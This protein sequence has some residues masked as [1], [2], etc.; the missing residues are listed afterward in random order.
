MVMQKR[1]A[2]LPFLMK[3]V[4]MNKT[5]QMIDEAESFLQELDP[6]RRHEYINGTVSNTSLF[7]LC[8]EHSNK[9]NN[10]AFFKM[11]IKNGLVPPSA[12]TSAGAGA[13]PNVDHMKY[14][15]EACISDTSTIE[16]LVKGDKCFDLISYFCSNLNTNPDMDNIDHLIDILTLN[17]KYIAT[18]TCA[19]KYTPLMIALSTCKP[20]KF[21][22]SL[23]RYR[24]DINLQD[25]K[26]KTALHC[27]IKSSYDVSIVEKL[28][29]MGACTDIV[30]HKNM[31]MLEFAIKHGVTIECMRALISGM[32][33]THSEFTKGK[34]IISCITKWGLSNEKIL[35]LFIDN[36]INLHGQGEN[37]NNIAHYAASICTSPQIL[38]E[39]IIAYKIY[40]N[41]PNSLLQCPLVIAIHRSATPLV[42]IMLEHGASVNASYYYHTDN[43]LDCA[44][45]SKDFDIVQLLLK[46]GAVGSNSSL[47]NLF[48][49]CSS[50][51]IICALVRNRN[52]YGSD[53]TY[54]S[55]TSIIDAIANKLDNSVIVTLLK[56]GA[57]IN[58][59]KCLDLA[60]EAGIIDLLLDPATVLNID[61][62]REP[63]INWA[64]RYH[65]GIATKI[66]TK[67]A[68]LNI[69]YSTC[70]SPIKLA[71][72][73]KVSFDLLTLCIDNYLYIDRHDVLLFAINHGC[74]ISIIGYL[75]RAGAQLNNT[76]KHRST[77]FYAL[78]KGYA[79]ELIIDDITGA[80]LVPNC[81]NLLAVAL[82][83]R[84]D[85][86]I[87]D[88]LL[89]LYDINC[90]YN[91]NSILLIALQCRADISIIY[92]LLERGADIY[93]KN[94]KN[95]SNIFTH[96]IEYDE[97]RRDALIRLIFGGN[98]V[99]TKNA[100]TIKN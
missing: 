6:V 32:H 55:N 75:I 29:S 12:S 38:K 18:Q 84:L 44:I 81:S 79:I 52:D 71:I 15:F 93:A 30:A 77:A 22:E 19:R 62:D 67:D 5:T 27:A 72:E 96:I 73:T 74:D 21:I 58:I 34:P 54:L 82:E 64:L 46:H 26:H 80:N 17:G 43:P 23:L 86:N 36:D 16:L 83:Q 2:E 100:R 31:N 87:V 10:E 56:Y 1:S 41:Q 28:I 98:R 88:A 51:D 94:T 25:F 53:H 59:V 40:I 33:A 69:K 95:K 78:I 90:R 61:T 3:M 39:I 14:F 65:P 20:I 85:I 48:K 68:A 50:E 4:K 57:I 91:N 92:L 42:E 37:G 7:S 89:N 24:Q 70:E 60:L 97:D 49:L 11:L 76:N 63:A 35:Q 47:A 99:E 45:E 66:I 8:C 13:T 9:N